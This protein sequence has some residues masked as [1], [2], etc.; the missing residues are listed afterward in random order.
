MGPTLR[1]RHVEL[2][3]CP[4]STWSFPAR[5]SSS[6]TRPTTS[7][8]LR[9]DLTWLTSSYMCI[10]G[11]GCHGIYA[12]AP[13]VGCCTLGA[14]F[15]DKD[16]EK[17]VAT[18]VDHARR[19]SSGSSEAAG[20]QGAQEGLD[21]A[22]TTTASARPAP[23]RSTA[24][25]RASSTTA[26]TSRRRRRAAPC[27]HWRSS[28]GKNPLETKPDVCWQLPIRRTFRNVERQDGT[29]TPRSRS[30]STTG[31]AGGPAATTWTGTARATPRRTSR[32]EPVYVTHE[33]ELAE[34]MGTAAYDELVRHCEA[35]LRSRSA[36]GA[37][38]RRPALTRP[39]DLENSRRQENPTPLSAGAGRLPRIWACAWT[40]SPSQ[41]DR[42]ASPAPPSASGDCSARTSPT[43]ACT[44]ASAP[45]T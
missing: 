15:A 16:D 22:S 30:A 28:T 41:P 19:R 23:S 14:H 37:A 31:A 25:R 29:S 1:P 38:P 39:P 11:Q 36:A 40:I 27:T 33:A 3:A 34:L 5:S 6:P 10:F 18:Y 2:A 42:M 12:D 7:E 45:A 9:C 13:D 24:S 17:R 43:A 20:P 21:R 26:P 8:V 35:H 32:A 4:K 44:P